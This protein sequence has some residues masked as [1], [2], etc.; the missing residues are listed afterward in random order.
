MVLK[1]LLPL[2]LLGLPVFLLAQSATDALRF[3]RLDR[4]GGARNIGVMGSMGAL[5]ADFGVL[6][7]NPA[8]LASYRRSELV[9]TPGMHVQQMEARLEGSENNWSRDAV[10]R[11]HL[12][13]GGLVVARQPLSGKWRTSNV[14]IGLAQLANYRQRM[15]YEGYALGSLTDRFLELANGR[16]LSQLDDFEAGLAWDAMAILGPDAD[17]FYT[18]DF[19]LAPGASSLVRKQQLVGRTGYLN[20]LQLAFAGNYLDRLSIGATIGVPLL[21]YTEN[22]V[23]EEVDEEGVIPFFTSLKWDENLESTGTGINLRLGLLYR[24]NQMVRLGLAVHTPTAMSITDNYSKELRYRYVDGDA[25]VGTGTSPEGIF[26]YR[27]YTPWR[28]LGSAGFIFGANGFLNAEVEWVDYGSASFNF[29]PQVTNPAFREAE[30]RA[31]QAIS[32]TLDQALQVRLGG[33]WVWQIFRFRG[34]LGFSGTE[35][36]RDKTWAPAWSLG[37]GI[38]EDDFFIDL[39]FMRQHREEGFVPYQTAEAPEL[40]VRTRLVRDIFALTIGIKL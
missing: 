10:N 19:E 15:F 9:L 39:G 34:G 2:I 26:D 14:A 5:G 29:T 21:S 11:F 18:S 7:T 3:S 13:H 25:F 37:I 16:T 8:G 36:A 28:L 1:R 24:V 17:L 27:L 38:R 12:Q 32:S 40:R 23:Y 22:R 30:Q 35:Y 4:F 31:N 20:E 6:S 33:E